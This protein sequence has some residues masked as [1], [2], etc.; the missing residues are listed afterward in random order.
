MLC[1]KI[2]E[3]INVNKSNLDNLYKEIKVETK[4]IFLA[5]D[6]HFGAPNWPGRAT[7]V[8]VIRASQLAALQ[9]SGVGLENVV[10]SVITEPFNGEQ[11]FKS[12]DSKREGFADDPVTWQ[13]KTKI[14]IEKLKREGYDPET[15]NK[16]LALYNQEKMNSRST[17]LPE[18]QKEMFRQVEVPLFEEIMDKGNIVYVG[19]G[20]HWK[21]TR[22]VEDEASV[23]TSLFDRKYS[24]KGLLE[25]GRTSRGNSFSIEP[26]VLP[27][28]MGKKINVLV[29]H[30]MWHGATEIGAI[31][32]QAVGTKEDALFVL[33]GDRHQGGAI[34][35]R[36][37]FGALDYGKQGVTPYVQVIGKAESL[38]GTMLVGYSPNRDLFFSTRTYL[39]DVVDRIVD[40]NNKSGI[41]EIC[42][43][44]IKQ[45]LLE[46]A[47]DRE[48]RQA[49]KILN[50]YSSL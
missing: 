46:Q 45:G 38:R 6:L 5:N 14:L 48:K 42:D 49:A 26:V 27:S 1:E 50:K 28:N 19:T 36:S 9:S 39:N 2:N 15:I 10:F 21:A 37:R 44:V 18:D 20:N 34:A 13:Q 22:G 40:W 8:D 32:R 23:V 35:E 4:Y 29:S 43:G 31:M 16:Y 17:F 7:N 47:V 30:K 41:L 25:S 12:H 3:D 24:E 11:A 33:A